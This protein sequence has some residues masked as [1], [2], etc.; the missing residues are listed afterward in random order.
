M[1]AA[2]TSSRRIRAWV[3]ALLLAAANGAFA[4]VPKQGGA[5]GANPETPSADTGSKPGEG[6]QGSGLGSPGSASGGAVFG[7]GSRTADTTSAVERSRRELRAWLASSKEAAGLGAVRDLLWSIAEPALDEGVP[8]G[9]FISRIREAVAKGAVPEVIVKALEADA[10]R[11]IWVARIVQ[12][13]SWPPSKSAVDFYLASSTALRNGLAEPAARSLVGWAVES[14]ASAEKIGA[15]MTT[16]ASVAIAYRANGSASGTPLGDAAGI[17]ARS[18]LR[19]GQYSIVAELAVRASVAGI[20]A[21]RFMISLEATIGRGR[22]VAE[23][24]KALFG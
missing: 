9:A 5:G 18:R 4:Q 14:G 22:S 16:A 13:S 11:W 15:A 10:A 1:K 19:V 3:L 17:L 6:S 8:A 2:K 24:E 12:G 23:F 20:D 7:S 21:G